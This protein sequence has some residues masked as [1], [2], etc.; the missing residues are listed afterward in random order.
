[1]SKQENKD[2]RDDT[3]RLDKW[4]WAARFFKTRSLASR[5]IDLGRV[6]VNGVKVNSITNAAPRPKLVCFTPKIPK[7]SLNAKP[8]KP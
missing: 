3:M 4:L 2:E 7:P 5:Q 1:M 6:S 8:K